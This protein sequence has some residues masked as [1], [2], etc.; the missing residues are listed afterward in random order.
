MHVPTNLSQLGEVLDVRFR[1]PGKQ[2]APDIYDLLDLRGFVLLATPDGTTLF[3]VPRGEPAKK[4]VSKA[5]KRLREKWSA[6]E[7]DQV[8]SRKLRLGRTTEII[9]RVFTIGYRSDKWTGRRR[10]YEHPYE[11]PPRLSRSGEVYR[12]AGGGQTV[13]ALGIEG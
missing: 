6:L 13:T 9:G 1:A 7:S 2:Y 4:D 11:S 8:F 10:D 5:A 3:F 12:L